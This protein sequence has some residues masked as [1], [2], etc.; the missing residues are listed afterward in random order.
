MRGQ[1]KIQLTNIMTHEELKA[2]W[3][4]LVAEDGTPN[5]NFWALWKEDKEEM[6]AAGA[7]VE[8][9]YRN[10]FAVRVPHPDEEWVF[11]TE[12]FQCRADEPTQDANGTYQVLKNNGLIEFN[13]RSEAENV[14]AEK[15]GEVVTILNA[16]SIY[17]A[18]LG[19]P[20][21]RRTAKQEKWA[22]INSGA[23]D[24]SARNEEIA[25]WLREGAKPSGA[26]L[27][28]HIDE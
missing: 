11:L 4:N 14:A 23:S 8:K 12:G 7:V 17:L 2:G 6:R 13:A 9:D 25:V 22:K 21:K 24:R 26:P 28:V 20:R 27:F 1:R 5:E 15:G 16:R 3:N 18:S 19:K 10:T